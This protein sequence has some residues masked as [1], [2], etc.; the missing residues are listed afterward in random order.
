MK[1]EIEFRDLRASLGLTQAELAARLGVDARTIR[2]LEARPAVES[3]AYWRLAIEA[4]AG[5][6]W[7]ERLSVVMWQI[8]EAGSRGLLRKARQTRRRGSLPRTVLVEHRTPT[9]EDSPA[10]SAAAPTPDRV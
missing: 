5:D 3:P 7:S 10:G 1:P 4:L 8:Q 2:R 9:E 6:L